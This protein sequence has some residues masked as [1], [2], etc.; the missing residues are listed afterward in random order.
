MLNTKY[1]KDTVCIWVLPVD[2]KKY[3]TGTKIAFGTVPI[4]QD[5]NE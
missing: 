2:S 1:G 4:L 3:H 5:F